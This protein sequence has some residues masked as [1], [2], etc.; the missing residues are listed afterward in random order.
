MRKMRVKRRG[1]SLRKGMGI[2]LIMALVAST[3]FTAL[4][5]GGGGEEE[6]VEE[7]VSPANPVPAAGTESA[8]R[9]DAADL[10]ANG[11]VGNYRGALTSAKFIKDLV[12]DDVDS[13]YTP[14]TPDVTFN[15][16][17]AGASGTELTQP[18]AAKPG[19]E[20]GT[21]TIGYKE[22]S[23]FTAGAVPFTAADAAT[24]DTISADDGKYVRKYVT[25]DFSGISDL[26][27]KSPGTYRYVITETGASYQA[28]GGYT[29][30]AGD[31]DVIQGENQKR[32]LD[33][34]VVRKADG[35][36]EIGGYTLRKKTETTADGDQYTKDPGFSETT[37]S[38]N[39]NTNDGGDGAGTVP[40]TDEQFQPSVSRYKT[41]DLTLT[42]KTAGLAPAD[43]SF[44]FTLSHNGP[45]SEDSDA[46]KVLYNVT[47]PN[48]TSTT[49]A[50]ST[51]RG[52]QTY[53]LQH[54]QSVTIQG[55]PYSTTVSI[56]EKNYTN[57]ATTDADRLG[58]SAP[59][60]TIDGT[61]AEN[62][63]EKADHTAFEKTGIGANTRVQGSEGEQPV[64]TD[65]V[66]TNDKPITPD[67]GLVREFTPYA[68]MIGIAS[69]LGLGFLKRRR[70]EA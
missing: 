45:Q 63:S 48:G 23:N 10:S 42:K 28:R 62:F 17:I 24:G 32:Y 30:N 67:T 61:A 13:A 33:V 47:T 19:T 41:Y 43:Q 55:L 7:E 5:E 58:Y 20:L 54:G 22:G 60:M 36:S 35:T 31:F 18:S 37:T 6:G 50:T 70:E 25:V 29:Y 51:L 27:T 4:A 12:I 2:A 69:L 56:A 9:T 44:A 21:P 68:A 3:S 34:H 1:F 59:T 8:S 65:V 15:Y 46:N 52:A 53:N 64:A 11:A 57:T 26:S 40:P 16:S 49:T 14:T 38:Y 66:V 39:N